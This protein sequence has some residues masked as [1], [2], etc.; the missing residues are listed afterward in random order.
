[1]ISIAKPMVS[2][3]E[4][5]KV[6]EVMDSGILAS[7]SYVKEFENEF[8]KFIGSEYGIA[9]SN[10][11]TALHLALEAAGIGEG[12]KVLTTPFTFIASSNAILYCGAKPVFCDIDEKT[13][14]IDP[15]AIKEE[16]EKD[17][18]ISALLIVHLYGLACDM[19]P[20]MELVEEYDLVLIEDCAQAHGA[21]YKGKSVGTFGDVGTFSF[22]PTK[23]MTTG[24]G[25]MLVTDN[26]EIAEKA[27]ILLNQ[28][29]ARR[30]YHKVL[31]YNYRMTNIAA[32][33]GLVQL[34]KL[35]GFNNKRQKNAEFLSGNINNPEVLQTPIVPEDCKHVF[36]QYTIT[37]SNRENFLKHLE[38]NEIGYGVYYPLPVYRQPLYEERGY[39]SIELSVTEDLI[40]KVVS[41]PI[42]PGLS[43]KEV[44]KI[45][46]VV[47]NYKEA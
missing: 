1:M 42:H 13:Y 17:P 41:L 21:T 19:D 5:E 36:H 23:N 31:G 20:I 27:Q 25:G 3:E 37:V 26:Q 38:E 34:K 10:G 47:N 2:N 22:Y 18:D 24:E 16:L 15:Q 14:N 32:A 7:G 40:E 39:G 8:A 28:G 4:K 45:V 6:L 33:I 9:C 46:E 11:T 29:S 35:E 12:D 30:Y 44:L 43:E